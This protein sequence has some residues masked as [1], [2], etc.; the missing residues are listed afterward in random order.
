MISPW[1]PL[2]DGDY[3]TITVEIENDGNHYR[4]QKR[5]GSQ[6]AS[7][8]R[9]PDGSE[10]GETKTIA[11]ILEKICGHNEATFRHVFF[12]GHDELESTIAK[13]DTHALDLRDIRSLAETGKESAGDV[14]QRR[15]E[16]ILEDR[17]KSYFSRWDDSRQRPNAT[18]WSRK[19]YW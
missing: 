19:S 13:L 7:S 12:T 18:E 17:I 4:L 2:P 15:L 14:D 10:L 1:F 6:A 11:A 9:T 5:W 8:L 16:Q 3:A